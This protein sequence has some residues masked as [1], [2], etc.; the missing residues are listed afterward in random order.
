MGMPLS[1]REEFPTIS[2]LAYQ[3]YRRHLHVADVMTTPVLS[4]GPDMTMKDVAEIM[5][6][7][8]VGS[9]V[10]TERETPVGIVTER[11]LLGKVI[12]QDREPAEVTVRNVMSTRLVTVH[13]TDTIKDAARTMIKQKGRLV[14]LK[15]GM[16]EGIVTASDLIRALPSIPETKLKVEDVMTRKVVSADRDTPVRRVAKTMGDMRIGSVLVKDSGKPTGIFTER[17]LL[18]KV[19][20]RGL[21]METAV[22][23]V[24]STPLITI[25]SGSSI[26]KTALTMAS[27][28]I[29]RLPVI[30]G[31]EIVGIVTARDLVE[32]YSK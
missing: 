26:H 11:D 9:L 1:L 6:E 28:H 15:E 14:V 3:E 18:T 13:P 4:I 10:V 17:D 7:R 31:E 16:V 25:A 27:K 30:E 32:A 19:L 2:D 22:G 29:R 21:S 12:A 8:H 23:G 24:A 5:G 20:A